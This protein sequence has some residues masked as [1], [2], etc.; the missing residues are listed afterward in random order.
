M[1]EYIERE[2][3]LIDVDSFISMMHVQAKGEPIQESA[4]KLVETARD[5]IASL[6]AADVAEVVRCRDCKN[7]CVGGVWFGDARW[8]CKILE[9]SVDLDFFADLGSERRPSMIIVGNGV[10]R[11]RSKHGEIFG[12]WCK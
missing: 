9:V 10:V 2:S 12:K 3:L 8:G 7:L 1:T 4:I 11:M 5:Y 6:T